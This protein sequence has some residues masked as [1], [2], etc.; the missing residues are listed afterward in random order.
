MDLP[1]YDETKRMNCP[2]YTPLSSIIE[3]ADGK[4][5]FSKHVI[6]SSRNMAFNPLDHIDITLPVILE[7]GKEDFISL[8]HDM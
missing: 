6:H 4:L 7:D 2:R 5:N 3:F 1:K 8:P